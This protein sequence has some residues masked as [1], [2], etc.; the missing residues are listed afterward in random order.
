MLSLVEWLRT[1]EIQKKRKKNVEQHSNQGSAEIRY[2]D[3]QGE[4]N[5][6][7]KKIISNDVLY[8]AEP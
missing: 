5:R 3:Q 2:D 7:D 4:I 6:N 8:I 1:K